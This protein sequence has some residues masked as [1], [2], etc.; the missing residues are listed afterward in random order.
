[1]SGLA[2]IDR[3]LAWRLFGLLESAPAEL[4]RAHMRDGDGPA[5]LD[6][7]NQSEHAEHHVSM[8]AADLLAT[9]AQASGRELP[10]KL[11][12][13]S[14][15][16][17]KAAIASLGQWRELLRAVPLE[18]EE[19]PA[20]EVSMVAHVFGEELPR[21]PVDV[22]E[23]WQ[24]GDRVELDGDWF[25]VLPGRQWRGPVCLV[26]LRPVPAEHGGAF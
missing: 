19:A 12:G 14:I 2:A 11:D 6:A 26:Q 9:L 10:A 17:A 20:G 24:V 16:A 3:A 15:A 7:L 4:L 25:V 22:P 23:A 18:V 5:I 8:L 13:S 1:M 21:K